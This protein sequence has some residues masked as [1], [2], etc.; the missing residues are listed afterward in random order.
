MPA[1]RISRLAAYVGMV[2]AISL[3]LAP[4]TMADWNQ[5][6]SFSVEPVDRSEIS[7]S[8]PIILYTNLPPDAQDAVRAAIESPDGY[9]VVYGVDDWPDRFFYSDYARPGRGQYVVRYDGDYYRLTT[10][11]S[12]GFPIG[13]WVLELPFII[14]GLLLARVANRTSRGEQ[15]TGVLGLVTIPGIGFH[16]IGPEFDFPILEP[17]QFVWL[18][19][20]AVIVMPTLLW[21]TSAAQSRSENGG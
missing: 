19:M 3:I 21:V 17:M 13:F 9:H 20:A 11:A 12:R 14:Y 7:E 6:A 15:S 5:Q 10:F 4:F 18:G 16:L 2:V 1:W 8:M